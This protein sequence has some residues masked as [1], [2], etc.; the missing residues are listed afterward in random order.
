MTLLELREE[1]G[2]SVAS[3]YDDRQLLL[4]MTPTLRPA[5]HQRGGVQR[6]GFAFVQIWRNL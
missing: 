4:P 1:P 6:N 2:E 5:A 3:G